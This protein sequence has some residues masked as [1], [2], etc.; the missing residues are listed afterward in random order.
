MP[1]G[2]RTGPAGAGPMTGRGAGYCAGYAV[3][4]Y[5]NPGFSRGGGGFGRGFERGWSGRGRGWRNR[6]WA[7]GFPVP[8]PYGF[9]AYPYTQEP[10]PKQEAELLK[11]E[12]DD[13][14]VQLEEI[15][16]RIDTLE[17]AEK[18]TDENK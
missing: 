13:L 1:R 12:A 8:M 15:Q 11:Q 9:P 16:S 7:T 17:K 14:K 2:D 18:T 6:Y 5:V 10:T 4:G 3:P